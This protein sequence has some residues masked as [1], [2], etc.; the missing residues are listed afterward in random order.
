MLVSCSTVENWAIWDMNS[1]LSV[2]FVG[3]CIFSWATRIFRNVSLSSALAFLLSSATPVVP[4]V[5]VIVIGSAMALGADVDE[6]PGG[7]LDRAG[8]GGHGGLDGVELVLRAQ[9]TRAAE[10]VLATLGTALVVRRAGLGV[11]GQAE[12]QAAEVDAAGLQR[13]L[14]VGGRPLQERQGLRA[15]GRD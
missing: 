2:G 13:A 1:E 11:R 8:R 9:A 3:S 4:L 5:P 10:R 12:V 15:V 14:E 7:E 6:R